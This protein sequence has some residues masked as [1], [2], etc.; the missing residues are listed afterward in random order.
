MTFDQFV[1]GIKVPYIMK[2]NRN[3]N[4]TGRLKPIK[5]YN[6]IVELVFVLV[7]VVLLL[8]LL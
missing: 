2:V 4:H 6:S 8:L 1:K 7:Y 5:V 3:N